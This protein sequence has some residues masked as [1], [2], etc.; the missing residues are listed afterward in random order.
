MNGHSM[1]NGG[2][3]GHH[4][5]TPDIGT[6]GV[7]D[8]PGGGGEDQ[9]RGRKMTKKKIVTTTST[10][11]TVKRSTSQTKV[12]NT[13]S[14]QDDDDG[15]R[16]NSPIFRRNGD[17]RKSDKN[18]A[19]LNPGP[20]MRPSSSCGK[21]S[22]YLRFSDQPDVRLLLVPSPN[23]NKA[24]R[25]TWQS[26]ASDEKSNLVMRAEALR[27]PKVRHIDLRVEGSDQKEE[28]ESP[29]VTTNNGTGRRC[30]LMSCV[31]VRQFGQLERG[32]MG[33]ESANFCPA[34]KYNP[35]DIQW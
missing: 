26:I 27:R 15:C 3:N 4:C 20:F 29:A 23:T 33:K 19:N 16:E 34:G 7:Q 30:K 2:H 17:S 28:E 24:D 21:I 6:N 25:Y 35:L 13:D 5:T 22:K 8:H 31:V 11:K 10:I 32:Q 12:K 14:C 18:V 1:E 9:H